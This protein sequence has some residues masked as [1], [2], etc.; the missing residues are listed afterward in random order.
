[1]SS[2][3]DFFKL[4]Q[5]RVESIIQ[6][7]FNKVDHVAP[8]L[9]KAINYSVFNGG[10]RFRPTLCYASALALDASL[11]Q[12][13]GAAAAIELVH[14]YS[15]IHDDLPAMDDDDLRRGKPS[16]H[17]AFDEATAILAG[18]ALQAFSFE[19]LANANP[20]IN[21]QLKLNM[22]IQLAQASGLEG[23]AA[24][25]GLDLASTNQNCS[26]AQLEKI[27]NFK[28][29]K[30]ISACSDLAALACGHQNSE[31]HIALQQYTAA[32]GL[33]FQVKDDIL[34]IEGETQTLGKHKGSDQQLN[35]STYPSLI[36]LDGARAKAQELHQQALDSL[37]LFGKEA[38]LLRALSLY[39][40]HREH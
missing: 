12:V 37:S 1:M 40:I 35:K 7:H 28:T 16:C 19:L 22:I 10:K 17:K 27:H 34:D 9:N 3:S 36:G 39:V 8:E 6:V 15:L 21:S 20:E 18:D 2:V 38:D 32:I 4:C 11:D 13:D 26:L 30:I 23:M 25:Q 33:S 29:G 31:K 5:K 14:C 24:G